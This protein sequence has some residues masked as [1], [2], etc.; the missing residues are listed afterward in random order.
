MFD[1]KY[2]DEKDGNTFK[3]FEFNICLVQDDLNKQKNYYF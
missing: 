2:K 1:L 3:Y